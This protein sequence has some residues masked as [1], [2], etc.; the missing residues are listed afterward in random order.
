MNRPRVRQVPEGSEE[1]RKMEE[2]GCE[3]ICGERT[4][5]A[6]KGLMNVKVKKAWT[7]MIDNWYVHRGCPRCS[8]QFSSAPSPIGSSGGHEVRFSRDP[9]PVFSA[10]GHGE[11]LCLCQDMPDEASCCLHVAPVRPSWLTRRST[12]SV[13]GDSVAHSERTHSRRLWLNY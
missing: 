3:V 6:V 8:V 10:A 4:T 13:K 12:P 5:P 2:S 9:L 1:H 7:P 11:L